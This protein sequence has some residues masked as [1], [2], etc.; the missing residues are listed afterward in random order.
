[1]SLSLYFIGAAFSVVA[2]FQLLATVIA[3]VVFNQLYTPQTTSGD[4]LRSP[5]IV[6]WFA[7]VLWGCAIILTLYV[8]HKINVQ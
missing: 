5:K 1:M 4:Y 3:T 7:A 6:Y 8:Y 2:A